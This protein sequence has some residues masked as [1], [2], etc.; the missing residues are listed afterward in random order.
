M[1]PICCDSEHGESSQADETLPVW[2]SVVFSNLLISFFSQSLLASLLTLQT[3]THTL[4]L[5]PVFYCLTSSSGSVSLCLSPHISFC[6]CLHA[7]VYMPCIS[8][9]MTVYFLSPFFPVPILT[10]HMIKAIVRRLLLHSASSDLIM[11]KFLRRK[12]LKVKLPINNA[13]FLLAAPAQLGHNINFLKYLSDRKGTIK[14]RCK[15]GYF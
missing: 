11:D 3:L 1:L 6:Y 8:Q 15:C 5:S 7:D 4:T 12:R 14:A 9:A 10:L 2:E 13:S